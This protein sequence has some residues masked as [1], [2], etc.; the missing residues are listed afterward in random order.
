MY[1][2]YIDYAYLV[3]LSSTYPC[4][5][6]YPLNWTQESLRQQ[7]ATL[8]WRFVTGSCEAKPQR[9]AHFLAMQ[10]KKAWGWEPEECMGNPCHVKRTCVPEILKSFE[11][12][13]FAMD[14]IM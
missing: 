8:Q 9:P 10:G 6:Y 4:Y 3:L 7:L 11:I 5:P 2:Q 13:Y 12:S 14:T 1:L